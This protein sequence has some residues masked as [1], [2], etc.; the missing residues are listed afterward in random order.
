[1]TQAVYRAKS[2]EYAES[3][4]VYNISFN[5]LV[6]LWRVDKSVETHAVVYASIFH[7][8][9]AFSDFV[10]IFHCKDDTYV[11]YNPVFISFSK[12]FLYGFFY[13]KP[14]VFGWYSYGFFEFLHLEHLIN[15]QIIIIFTGK[16]ADRDTAEVKKDKNPVCR[17]YSIIN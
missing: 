13:I 9:L 2:D 3:C 6:K 4:Y 8:D 15:P 14:Y 16:Q 11:F 1:M 17:L 10:Y 7:N 5:Y 12:A